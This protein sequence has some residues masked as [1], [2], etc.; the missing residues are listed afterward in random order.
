M[1][2]SPRSWSEAVEGAGV[3]DLWLTA[4]E[5]QQDI[6]V[7]FRVPIRCPQCW[8]SGRSADKQCATC[9]GWCMI[10][11]NGPLLTVPI[12]SAD[13]YDGIEYFLGSPTTRSATNIKITIRVNRDEGRANPPWQS[14]AYPRMK[15]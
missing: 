9:R 5:L 4:N 13:F 2:R 6:V 15:R 7:P 1:A 8:G 11:G 10:D 12:S 14:Q 3:V